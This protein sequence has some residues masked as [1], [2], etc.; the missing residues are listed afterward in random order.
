M[1]KIIEKVDA[2]GSVERKK[3]SGRPLSARTQA[4]VEGV[5]REVYSQ[6]DPDTGEWQ[7]HKS[8]SAISKTLGISRSSVRRIIVFDLNLKCYR[9][10]KTKNLTIGDKEKRAVRCKRLLRTFTR[11]R[12]SKTFFSDEKS[13]FPKAIMVSVAVSM[14]GKTSL[15]FVEPGVKIN[16]A[17]YCNNVLSKMIPEMNAISNRHY[18]FQQD[19]AR[20]HTSRCMLSYLSDHLPRSAQL[21]DPQDWPTN[22]PDLN[23]LDYSV[24]ASLEQKVNIQNLEHLGQRLIEAWESMEQV[25]IDKIIGAFRKRLKA[26]ITAEGGRFEHLLK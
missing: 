2:T 4:N 26:C 12:L 6:E 14:M 13:R 7:K 25:E 3:G 18:T 23:P 9:R 8:P 22:S 1:Q 5:E 10:I 11:E 17:Y 24:W 15:I 21:L 19:G 20:S 16:S